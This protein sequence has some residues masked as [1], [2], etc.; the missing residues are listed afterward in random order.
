MG[1]T[2]T[3]QESGNITDGSTIEASHFNNEFNQ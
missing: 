1:T 3:R 2:Y